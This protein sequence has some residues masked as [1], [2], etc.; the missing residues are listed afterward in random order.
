ML[1]NF[2]KLIF[3]NEAKD[4]ILEQASYRKDKNL[5]KLVVVLFYHSGET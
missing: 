2:I 4:F 5:D 3:S 1:V